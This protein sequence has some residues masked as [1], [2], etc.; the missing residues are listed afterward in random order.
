VAGPA[1]SEQHVQINS[2]F[3]AVHIRLTGVRIYIPFPDANAKNL[4]L[5]AL[6]VS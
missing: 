3:D 6:P 5:M 4:K 1:V 2:R